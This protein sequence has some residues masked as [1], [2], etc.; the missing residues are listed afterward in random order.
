MAY[1]REGEPVEVVVKQGVPISVNWQGRVHRI[2]GISKTWRVDTGWW[3]VRQRRD[4][5]KLLTTTG[6]LL[7]LAHDLISHEWRI[8]RVYD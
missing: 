2:K 5:Y 3:R 8:F 1:W 4:Y 6:L 7:I